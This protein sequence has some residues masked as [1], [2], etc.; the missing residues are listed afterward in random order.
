MKQGTAKVQCTCH[1]E[2]QDHAHGKGVRVAN[3]LKLP[4]DPKRVTGLQVRCTVCSRVHEVP[5]SQVS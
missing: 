1:H 5:V 2:F 4:P 3:S